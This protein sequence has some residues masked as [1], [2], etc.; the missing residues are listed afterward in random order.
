MLRNEVEKVLPF[1]MERAL[2]GDTEAQKLILE[3]CLPKQKPVEVPL[4]FT[5]LD[6]NCPAPRRAILEQAAEGAISLDT[7]E[8]IIEQLPSLQRE[9]GKEEAL[10]SDNFNA[11]LRGIL[12]LHK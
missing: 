9:E 8:K 12:Y 7:A 10:V 11:Y 4:E 5:L 6:E 3:R 1:V 2:N